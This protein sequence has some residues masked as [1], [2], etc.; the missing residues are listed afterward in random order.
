MED[1]SEEQ[2]IRKIQ[3]GE[4]N[5]FEHFVDKYSKVVYYYVLVRVNQ[6]R[7]DAED[8]VQNAFIKVYKALDRFD[9]KKKFYP[10]FFTIIKN[11]IIEFYRKNKK[12]L[13]LTDEIVA[14]EKDSSL[15]FKFLLLGLK[16]DYARVLKLYFEDGFSYD[17]ISREIK[18]PINTVK[19]LI[20]R[21]KDQVKNRIMNKE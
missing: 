14:E 12:H 20:R 2:I 11:E 9:S 7:Q 4:I 21:A 17:D 8:I 18:K 5:Y 3:N 6:N 10:Y 19:T 1:L 13:E 16:P 15:D